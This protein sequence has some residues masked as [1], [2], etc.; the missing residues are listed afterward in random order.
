[1]NTIVLIVMSFFCLVYLAASITTD[2]FI[3]FLL[4]VFGFFCS[5]AMAI[6]FYNAVFPPTQIS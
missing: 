6:S 3:E 2:S 4:Y 1:M 5:L